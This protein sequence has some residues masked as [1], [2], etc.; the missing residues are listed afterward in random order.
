MRFGES[1][2]MRVV[3]VRWTVSA[4]VTIA[5]LSVAFTVWGLGRLLQSLFE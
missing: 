1:R 4:F 2:D 3:P 5:F